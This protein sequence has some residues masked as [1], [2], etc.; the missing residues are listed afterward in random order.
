[1]LTFGGPQEP[2]TPTRARRP[3][4][5]ASSICLAWGEESDT[6]AAD[7]LR[8]GGRRQSSSNN[9]ASGSN[10]NSQNVITDRPTTRIKAPPGGRSSISLAWDDA[11]QSST[12]RTP[13][14]RSRPGVSTTNVEGGFCSEERPRG[15]SGSQPWACQISVED[16][17]ESVTEASSWVQDRPS[18]VRGFDRQ[19]AHETPRGYI[20]DNCSNDGGGSMSSAAQDACNTRGA[21]RG[22]VAKAVAFRKGMTRSNSDASICG[23][24]PDPR[25]EFS[26]RTPKG[27]FRDEFMTGAQR[28]GPDASE[29]S[30]DVGS[31]TPKA[32]VR[33]EFLR[34]A[35]QQNV[36][37]SNA[38]GSNSAFGQRQQRSSSNTFARGSDQNCGNVMTDRP[39]T[40]VFAPPG[41]VSSIHFG[42]DDA[43]PARNVTP[44]TP[45]SGE[46]SRMNG[47]RRH[48]MSEEGST[49]DTSVDG[50]NVTPRSGQ[51]K[52][53]TDTNG[54]AFGQ[55][56][57]RSSS[58][59]FARGADQN[60]GNMMTN[61]PTTRVCA[62]PGGA[63]SIS[64]SHDDGSSQVRRA[65]STPR[66]SDCTSSASGVT[67]RSVRRNPAVDTNSTGS[68]QRSSSNT[69]ARG[70]N[71][72]CGN[73]LTDRPT[74]RI[75]APP[76][77]ASSIDFGWEHDSKQAESQGNVTPRTPKAAVQSSTPRANTYSHDQR[78]LRNDCGGNRWDDDDYSESASRTTEATSAAFERMMEVRAGRPSYDANA[79][80]NLK[81]RMSK[82]QSS[83]TSTTASVPASAAASGSQIYDEDFGFGNFSVP[84]RQMPQRSASTP[85]LRSKEDVDGSRPRKWKPAKAPQAPPG[86]NP[87][88]HPASD[89]K[90]DPLLGRKRFEDM[91]AGNNRD[92]NAIEAL[93]FYQDD[94]RLGKHSGPKMK[95]I[96]NKH[97]RDSHRYYLAAEGNSE[98]TPGKAR[99]SSKA[100]SDPSTCACSSD[101]PSECDSLPLGAEWSS[102]RLDNPMHLGAF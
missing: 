36:L 43:K 12:P 81:A 31:R 20:R 87:T 38:S 79:L 34:N 37:A 64:L 26:S 53:V 40:R 93:R 90:I 17:D 6:H 91:G 35:H 71:Q 16:E 49:D 70:S 61:T 13:P 99:G 78:P 14:S 45:K 65:Q 47:Q 29:A 102:C 55:R 24:R 21:N 83:V 41:G 7:D 98:I 73:V 82:R 94:E 84:V 86:G 74:S 69:F 66:M 33:D 75:S 27:T 80:K 11:P 32:S 97:V 25:E 22:Q 76:G 54:A 95:P 72:N 18:D 58:N 44:R 8:T 30:S 4:G 101:V 42:G 15:G 100:S 3:P 96:A 28:R 2:V 77:G 60:C 46:Q 59:T 10:Q 39:T 19:G 85:S 57:Q 56:L 62:P 52:L 92:A 50:S 88:F 5:G 67:P 1:M 51:R 23:R 89:G 68:G 9:F 48:L 63:S